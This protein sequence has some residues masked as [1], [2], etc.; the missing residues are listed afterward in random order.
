M[1]YL[2][3]KVRRSDLM[4]AYKKAVGVSDWG[5][6]RDRREELNTLTQQFWLHQEILSKA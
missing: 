2:E 1:G 5:K 4:K 3:Y 6:A